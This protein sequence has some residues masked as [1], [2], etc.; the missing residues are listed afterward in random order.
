MSTTLFAESSRV[1]KVGKTAFVIAYW[2]MREA[3]RPQPLY[4]DHLAHLFLDDETEEMGRAMTRCSPSTEHLIHFR[5]CYYD[6]MLERRLA[7]GVGQVVLLGAGLDTRAIRAAARGARFFEIDQ[8]E[9]IAFKRHR[10]EAHRYE[11]GSTMIACNYVTE[12]WL[13]KLRQAGFDP[14]APAY[15]VWEGNSMYIPKREVVRLLETMRDGLA[16]FALSFDYLSKRLVENR[17]ALRQS[18]R[19]V[20][21]FAE[22]QA[23]WIT[24]FDR[25]EP[26]IHGVGLRV[27]EDHLLVE[28]GRSY[29][30][31]LPL[32]PQ[33][34]SDY[35]ICTVTK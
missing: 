15:I 13:G 10:L 3:E 21:G 9:V 20:Q 5:T 25:I 27:Q 16:D 1:E 26:L 33:L 19:I 32:D 23:P 31:G 22:M 29:R 6:E 2:R 17:A 14:S 11:L 7:A 8:P 18:Q 30:P 24:G 28:L 4:S 35:R 12:D 34:L